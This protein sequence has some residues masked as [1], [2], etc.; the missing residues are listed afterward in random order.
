[1][2]HQKGELARKRNFSFEQE[3]AIFSLPLGLTDA[4]TFSEDLGAVLHNCQVYRKMSDVEVCLALRMSTT[5]YKRIKKHPYTA[6]FSE[7]IRIC[8]ILGATMDF[9][10]LMYNIKKT[11]GIKK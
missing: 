6:S 1:M 7:I 2:P 8:K 11:K 10:S 9:R 3:R 4:M 5:R